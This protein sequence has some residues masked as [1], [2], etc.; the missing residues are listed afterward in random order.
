MP[1]AQYSALIGYSPGA[2]KEV[3]CPYNE[4]GKLSNGK[5]LDGSEIGHVELAVFEV[6]VAVLGGDLP[7]DAAGVTGGDHI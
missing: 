1:A 5:R 2:P 6:I 3:R 7:D 4:Y